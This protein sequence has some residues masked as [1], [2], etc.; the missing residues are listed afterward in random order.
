MIPPSAKIQS[1]NG[2]CTAAGNPSVDGP[3]LKKHDAPRSISPYALL[4]IGVSLSVVVVTY[5]FHSFRQHLVQAESKLQLHVDHLKFAQEFAQIDEAM[6]IAARSAM[7]GRDRAMLATYLENESRMQK[8]LDARFRAEANDP[9]AQKIL[10]ELRRTMRDLMRLE[11]GVLEEDKTPYFLTS[12]Y[13]D[14]RERIRDLLHRL[15][16]R[17][18]VSESAPVKSIH[19]LNEEFSTQNRNVF[20]GLG[21]FWLFFGAWIF[22]LRRS[23]DRARL[24]GSRE[25]NSLEALLQSMPYGVVAVDG[26]GEF[27]LWNRAAREIVPE[28]PNHLPQTVWQK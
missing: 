26:K 10:L 24:Q 5:H 13:Y 2:S 3:F 1:N 7:Q 22:W 4:I 16:S 28:G 15:N 18:L 11:G 20:I 19:V 6:S 17:I 12:D 25:R 14:A 21:I 27:T 9:G 8:L 23:Y